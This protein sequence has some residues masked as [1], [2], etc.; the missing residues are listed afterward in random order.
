MSEDICNY[1]EENIEIVK[2]KDFEI[3]IQNIHIL[4]IEKN[5]LGDTVISFKYGG[6][7]AKSKKY[8]R[9]LC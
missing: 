6:M 3:P 4:D 8:K 1:F 2:F 9:I 7:F 5:E